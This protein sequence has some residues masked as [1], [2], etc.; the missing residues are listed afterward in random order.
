MIKRFCIIL[1][2][3]LLIH[4]F[5]NLSY[6]TYI[7][8]LR[9]EVI[10]KTLPDGTVVPMWAFARDTYFEAHDGIPSVPGPVITIPETENEVE[11]Y[12]ENNL[13]VPISITI[14]G[15]YLSNNTGPV[16]NVG[17]RIQS[18]SHETPPGNTVAVKYEWQNF[19]SGTYLLHSGTDLAIQIP[20]GLYCVIKKDTASNQIYSSNTTYSN[21]AVIVLSEIDPDLNIQVNNNPG[22]GT[23]S[24]IDY[25]PKFFLV[26]GSTYYSGISPIDIGYAGNT[27]LLRIINA[28]LKDRVFSLGES[29]FKIIAEDGNEYPYYLEQFALFVA[30][31]QTKDILFTPPSEGYYPFFDRRLALKNNT[32]TTGGMLGYLKV[33]TANE[34]TLNVTKSGTGLGKVITS[35][36][37]GIDCGSDCSEMFNENSVVKLT[38]IP[39]INSRFVGWSGSCSGTG[40]CEI[41]MNSNKNVT[42]NFAP[43]TNIIIDGPNGGEILNTGMN[44]MI[45]WQAPS[46]FSKFSL[47]YSV[48]NG[49]KWILIGKNITKRNYFWKIPPLKTNTKKALIKVEGYNLANVRIGQDRS[50]NVFSIDTIRVTYPNA[51]GLIFTSGSP[52]Q[53]TWTTYQTLQPVAKTEIQYSTNGGLTWKTIATLTGNPGVYSGIVPAVTKVTTKGL[54]RVLLRDAKNSI[55]GN[56]RSDN[57]F[58]I[59]P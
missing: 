46:N 19:K 29:R 7:V 48:N 15:Q 33:K 13:P 47:F 16:R 5:N 30:A 26:N 3:L 18:F 14:P 38:A 12:L 23:I 32:Q 43:L 35:N 27:K 39:D 11:I 52:W 24:S 8:Y 22:I 4:L 58:T 44:Y 40:D 31:G 20:M 10:N 59:N 34:F 41:N 55:I 28:G 2:A 17:G 45:K 25:K 42:A 37:S 51:T 49:L 50:D 56:D 54:I 57:F 21:E 1:L 6:A 53:I 9:A 36:I